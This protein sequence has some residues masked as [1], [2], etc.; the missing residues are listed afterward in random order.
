M[1]SIRAAL[2]QHLRAAAEA[3]GG[4]LT[5]P[6]GAAPAPRA[7]AQPTAVAIGEPVPLPLVAPAAPS[8]A[9][10]PAAAT[11][12]MPLQQRRAA[13]QSAPEAGHEAN[14]QAL[15]ALKQQALACTRCGLHRTRDQVVFGEGNATPRVLFLGEAPGAK[16]DQTGRPFVGEAGQLLDRILQNAMGLARAEVYIA[17]TLKC[18]PPGN[19]DPAPEEAAQCLPFLQQQLAILRPEVIV[20]L[21]RVAARNLLSTDQSVTNLRGKALAYQGIPVVV[22]WHPA[23]LLREPGRKRETWEDIKRVNRL[24]GLPETPRPGPA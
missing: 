7:A 12:P 2:Q 5:L 3:Y 6:E 14:I 17:N 22:T 24:L 8:A 1:N 10:S 11:S 21:G 20:C 16:E 13:P 23:Y 19:R 4:D 18:R 9:P 15:A